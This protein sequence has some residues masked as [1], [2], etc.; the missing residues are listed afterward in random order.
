MK[1]KKRIFKKEV[2]PSIELMDNGLRADG[3][4]IIDFSI[5]FHP[6]KTDMLA[7][8]EHFHNLL[9]KQSALLSS[10][11]YNKNHKVHE[12]AFEALDLFAKEY[13]LVVDK[14]NDLER[15]AV[16]EGK[17]K[18]IEQA[19]EIDIKAFRLKGN[20]YYFYMEAIQLPEK[21]GRFVESVSGINTLPVK[22]SKIFPHQIRI[23]DSMLQGKAVKPQTFEKMYNFPA[24]LD[25]SG[26][27]IAIISLGGGYDKTVLH[28]Y[29]NDMRIPMPDIFWRG[30]DGARNN[31]GADIQYDYEV[32]MDVQIAASLAPGAK[33]IVYFAPNKRSGIAKAIKKAI[34]DRKFRASIVSISW[35]SLEKE[36]S[37]G[38]LK[39]LDKVL[40]EAAAL[41]VTVLTSSGDLG[42]SG[43]MKKAGDHTKNVQMPASHPLVLAVGGTEIHVQDE[44]IVDE[45]AWDQ[46]QEIMGQS[47]LFQTGGG[48]SDIWKMPVY[49]KEAVSA[50]HGQAKRRGIPDIA[51][52]ASTL[53]GFFFT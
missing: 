36:F 8:K 32:N 22:V 10:S 41:N 43:E 2:H 51:A 39:T 17:I 3:D 44:V 20:T 28:K 1:S 13:N 15:W 25:G 14:K 26:Q 49:Q 42:S 52:N 33:I 45:H 38:E 29:F 31:P 4:T 53:P 11:K 37:E 47:V 27:T 35:G 40:H 23:P 12:S 24:G 50:E 5:F 16:L 30:V 18:D 34:H 9:Q 48:F 46:T 6:L 7:D 19:L 21:I